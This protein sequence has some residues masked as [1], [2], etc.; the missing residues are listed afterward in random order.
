M[1]PH[2]SLYSWTRV[3]AAPTAFASETPYGL[4]VV[5]LDDGLRIAMRLMV[6]PNDELR[7]GQRIEVVV[8]SFLD[9][10]MFAGKIVPT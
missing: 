2:G 3:H 6:K 4:G 9:G 8:E 5:D 1:A 7:V 10:P